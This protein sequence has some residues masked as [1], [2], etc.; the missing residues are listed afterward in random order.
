MFKEKISK[1]LPLS[2]KNVP[3]YNFINIRSQN[4]VRI[5]LRQKHAR[6]TNRV[7]WI[8]GVFNKILWHV[9]PLLANES[10]NTFSPVTLTQATTE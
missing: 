5:F 6:K 2:I 3:T 7:K 1:Y 4:S 8:I 10:V 9:D